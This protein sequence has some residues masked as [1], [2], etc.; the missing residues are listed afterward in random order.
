MAHSSAEKIKRESEGSKNASMES[1]EAD[2]GDG[3]TN[4]Q[5][6]QN[7]PKQKKDRGSEDTLQ[8]ESQVKEEA[9]GD[10]IHEESQSALP[11]DPATMINYFQFL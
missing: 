9:K 5:S 6:R 4:L 11:R 3:G 1:E 2:P 7:S 10:Q 8:D